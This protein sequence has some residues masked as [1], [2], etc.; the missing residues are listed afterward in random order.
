[1]SIIPSLDLSL[2]MVLVFFGVLLFSLST[3]V[4]ALLADY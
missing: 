1:M 2:G 3:A 4:I